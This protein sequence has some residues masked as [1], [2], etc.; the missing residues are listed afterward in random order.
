MSR[1]TVGALLLL[2]LGAIGIGGWYYAAPWLFERQQRQTSDAP[3]QTQTIRIGGDNY[4]GYWFITSP[5]MRKQAA[6]RGLVI[7]FTD[8]GGAYADRLRKFA[9][10]EY[11]AIVLPINSYLQHGRPYHYPGVIV[12]AVAESRGADGIVAFADHLPSGKINDLNDPNMRIVYTAQ[13]PSAFLLDLTIADFDLDQLRATGSWRVEVGASREVYERAHANQGDVFVLW[14]PDLSRAL[15]LPGMRS[16]WSSGQF[17][18]YIVDVFVF[19]RD[20][21]Q[22]HRAAVLEF[23]DLYFRVLAIYANA[24]DKLIQEMAQSTT[25]DQAE[26]EN[27]LG[28][29]DWFDLDENCRLQFGIAGSLNAKAVEGVVNTIIACTDVLRRTGQFDKDPLDGNPYLITNS[30]ILEELAK[31]RI[32][33][34]FTAAGER[35]TQFAAL[36]A[37]GWKRLP[38]VG[39]FRVEPITFQT[40][41]N[42]LT[43]DGKAIVDRIAQLLVHNYPD[44]RVVI[45]GHTAPG[46][47]EAENEKL[48]L[49]RAEAVVQYL[50]AVHGIAENRLRAEGL[51]STS[52]PARKPQ[53][54]T[55]AYQY[56]MSRVEFVAVGDNPL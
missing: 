8:D 20:F 44:Y 54:P 37:D 51:G 56:R 18:G 22:N 13:S 49:E 39:T 15:K 3:Q 9:A 1:A 46:G 21:L 4:L 19:H 34:P 52:P 27:M 6:R 7:Q 36:D 23:L 29:I 5:E 48:S 14:E 32:A 35:A 43:E 16:V 30:G 11:D 42:L 2:L 24:R 26:I 38:E 45:R 25:L 41:N 53:E 17:S 33:S 50:K 28:K 31:R 47:D 40:W 10:G 12:A 55:R